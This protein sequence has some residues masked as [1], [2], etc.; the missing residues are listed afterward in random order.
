MVSPVKYWEIMSN[1]LDKHVRKLTF[2]I[3]HDLNTGVTFTSDIKARDKQK[4][5]SSGAQSRV[6][7][8][9][10][11]EDCTVAAAT[12]AAVHNLTAKPKNKGGKAQKGGKKSTVNTSI[13]AS[14]NVPTSH[15]EPKLTDCIVCSNK[16]HYM[17]ECEK[18]QHARGKDRQILTAKQK[19]CFR[20]LRM[21]AKYNRKE[22][23]T[24][25]ASHE[26]GCLTNWVCGLDK[27]GTLP[28]LKQF[29][30]L[31]CYFHVKQNVE[32]ERGFISELDK[33]IQKPGLKFF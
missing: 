21:D 32:H 16:H 24:W 27:C 10:A 17:F 28:K 22:V 25:W 3:N 23:E 5:S 30:I 29:H 2:S 9:T 1:F 11:D 31:M 7:T 8:S 12:T 20:C 4:S 13:N 18:F 26:K 15:V 14:I 33:S 19:A 6:Y